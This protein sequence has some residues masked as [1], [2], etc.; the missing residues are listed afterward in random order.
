MADETSKQATRRGA[1]RRFSTRWIKGSGIDIGCGTDSLAALASFF[2]LM[3]SL[4]PWD[5][6]DGDAMLMHGVDDASVDFVH[7]SHCLEHLVDPYLS[8][9]NWIRICREGGHLIITVPDEDLYE[10]GVWPSTFN[11]DHKWTFTI[12]KRSSWS[13]R[14][15]NIFDLLRPFLDHV[16]VLK[17][18]LLDS[19]FQYGQARHDQSRNSL[20]ESAIEIVLRKRA[21]VP[22]GQRDDATPRDL[23]AEAVAHH[24]ADRSAEAIDLYRGLLAKDPG[25]VA[26]AIN[27]ASLSGFHEAVELLERATSLKPDHVHA[28]SSYGA[29]LFEAGR[30]REAE[31]CF[32]AALTAAPHR[33]ALWSMLARTREALDDD[34]GAVEALEQGA[35]VAGF[36]ATVFVELARLYERTNRPESVITCLE[37]VVALD[38]GNKEARVLRGHARLKLGDLPGGADDMRW[39]WHDKAFHGQGLIFAPSSA[40]DEDLSSRRVLLAADAGIGDTILFVR[41]ARLLV[42]RGASVGVEC[43]PE[44]VRLLS[45]DP[46]IDVVVE[47]GTALPPHDV[48]VPIHNLIGAFGTTLETVPGDVPYLSVTSQGRST[49]AG[50]LAFDSTLKIGIVWAGNP[51]H[52]NDRRRS[53]DPGFLRP[54]LE[55]KGTTFVSLQK[56]AMSCP[57]DVLDWTDELHDMADTADLV[58]ALDLVISIDSSVAH[59]A[60]A[61][62]RPI[63][64]LD[65]FDGCWR[66]M[67][68]RPDSP[69]YPTMRI[70]R[71]PT[72]GD[73][74]AVVRGVGAALSAAV[75]AQRVE[76]R[77]AVAGAEEA[78]LAALP[79]LGGGHRDQR[80]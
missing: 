51:A 4:R 39:M 60:G 46:D 19:G 35:A 73:W 67:K 23:F 63:W 75:D 54:L 24:E 53:M 30:T 65:R 36:L 42:Q 62:G 70:F 74:A 48:R 76:T 33:H 7:S 61:L 45:R 20:S 28:Q 27:L 41:Y 1:D 8:L 47:R 11:T 44:L 25:D 71:Q 72:P 16:D 66:W 80:I 52:V 2:P 5:L 14:S 17:V 68:D 79:R 64:L 12:A 59:L 29:L 18:E 21:G 57:I 15:V 6:P 22:R 32:R 37:R 77:P 55:T 13:P 34:A 43:Q 58:A 50:R 10:Q 3:T 49:W 78:G 40:G 31:V 9:S 26:S 38:P 69:W 56:N